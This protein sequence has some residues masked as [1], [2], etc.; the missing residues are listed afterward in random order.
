MIIICYHYISLLYIII[1]YLIIHF[2]TYLWYI[3][4]IYHYYLNIIIVIPYIHT[5]IIID[6]KHHSEV[7]NYLRTLPKE[8]VI[9]LGLAFGL[10]Y[11]K[12]QNMQQHPDDMVDAWLRKED[13]V[14]EKSGAPTWMSLI[15]ALKKIG[16]N[17]IAQD[18]EKIYN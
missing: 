2:F 3:I 15:A 1:I 5:L 8:E 18:I 9:R 16:Q 12:L 13:D 4:T 10:S 14:Y 7:A 17:G 11:R 6:H